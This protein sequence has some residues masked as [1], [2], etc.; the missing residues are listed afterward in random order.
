MALGLR[1][2]VSF[3]QSHNMASS[4][5]SPAPHGR[6]L[7][8]E[9]AQFFNSVAEQALEDAMMRSSPSPEPLLGKRVRHD[10]QE[11]GGDH[12]TETEEDESPATRPQPPSISVSNLTTAALR[13]ATKKKLRP[14]QSEEVEAFFSVSFNQPWQ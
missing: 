3:P 9:G 14:E 11:D 7:R 4:Q 6:P 12:D 10:D 1:F 2:I 13:Y 8:R 5:T